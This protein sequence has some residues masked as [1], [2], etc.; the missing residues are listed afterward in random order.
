MPPPRDKASNPGM[1]PDWESN[2]R[3][4]SLWEDAQATEPHQ[5]G[6]LLC[7]L[8]QIPRSGILR[9]QGSQVGSWM[10]VSTL[11]SRKGGPTYP[12][13]TV[14]EGEFLRI[15]PSQDGSF[16]RLSLLLS[17]LFLLS[18]LSASPL[19]PFVYLA[20]KKYLMVL[21]CT[22]LIASEV[23]HFSYVYRPFLFLLREGALH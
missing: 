6:R 11:P 4:F 7:F 16:F 20:G 12:S 22:L 18:F 2:R 5:S 19:S 9:S 21:I 17:L 1:C 3:P 13:V 23:D 10:D 15:R 8:G 14:C